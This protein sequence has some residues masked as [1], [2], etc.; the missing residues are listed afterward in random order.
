MRKVFKVKYC[1][2]EEE[3]NEFLSKLDIFEKDTAL[4][5]LN[6]LYLSNITY[7][8]DVHGHGGQEYDV[9]GDLRDNISISNGIVAIIQYFRLDFGD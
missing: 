4:K 9:N 2:S 8:A 5:D 1:Y 7:M 3:T 6:Q